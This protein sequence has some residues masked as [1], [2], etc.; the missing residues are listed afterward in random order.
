VPPQ[1]LGKPLFPPGTDDDLEHDA[2][3]KRPA[4]VVVVVGL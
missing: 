3:Q 2:V 4:F 1:E